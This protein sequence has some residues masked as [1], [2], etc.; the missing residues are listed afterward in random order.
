MYI[1]M[2]KSTKGHIAAITDGMWHPAGY[3]SPLFNKFLTSSLD[4]SLRIWDATSKAVGMD[5]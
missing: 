5:Q 4:G 1:K 2:M 3:G